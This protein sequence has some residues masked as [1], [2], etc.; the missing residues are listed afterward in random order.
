MTTCVATDQ[1]NNVVVGG[2]YLSNNLNLGSTSLSNPG[3]GFL[4]KYD[5]EGNLIWAVSNT[6]GDPGSSSTNNLNDNGFIDIK[7]GDNGDIFAI[8]EF[9]GNRVDFSN[10]VYVTSTNHPMNLFLVKFN[11]SGEAQWA[12]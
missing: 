2:R 8:G 12:Q 7:T 6:G 1:N 9:S 11:S 10:G 4:A 5:P 3:N